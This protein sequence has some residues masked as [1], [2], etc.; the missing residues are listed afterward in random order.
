M[1]YNI[2]QYI[3]KLGGTPGSPLDP[4]PP[5]GPSNFLPFYVTGIIYEKLPYFSW[6]PGVY[7]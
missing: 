7:C 1:D 4:L 3:L 6:V 5:F 2:V